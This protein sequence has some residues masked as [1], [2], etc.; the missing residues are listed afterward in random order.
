MAKETPI[1][2]ISHYF[3]KINVAVVKLKAPLKQGDAI[4]IVGGEDTDFTQ[5]VSSMQVDHEEVKIGKKGKEVGLKVKK[6]VREG[7]FVYKA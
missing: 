4:R 1:G 6:K 3:S 5:P 2:K 7:Y